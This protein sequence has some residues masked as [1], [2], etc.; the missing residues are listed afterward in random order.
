MGAWVLIVIAAA[1]IVLLAAVVFTIVRTRRQ[2]ELRDWFGPD[3]AGSVQPKRIRPQS[4]RK[5]DDR[6]E[7]RQAP[8]IQPLTRE[9]RARFSA[10]WNQLH[11][12][13]VDRPRVVVLAADDLITQVM[14]D[15]GYPVDDFESNSELVSVDEADVVQNYRDAHTVYTKTTTGEASPEDLRRAVI[16]Y[17]VLFEELVTNDRGPGAGR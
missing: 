3:Y 15:C 6:D 1:V 8:K 7:R 4:E 17:R 9:A 10:Q 12:R 5:P 14:R 11:D 16:A 13:F 2:R